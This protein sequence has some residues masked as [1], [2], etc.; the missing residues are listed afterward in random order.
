MPLIRLDSCAKFTLPRTPGKA[1]P[2]EDSAKV[3][4]VIPPSRC[5]TPSPATGSW[6]RT[7]SRTRSRTPCSEAGACTPW[8]P[9]ASG[10]GFR[11]ACPWCSLTSSRT[12]PRRGETDRVGDNVYRYTYIP[13]PHCIEISLDPSMTV[14]VKTYI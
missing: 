14:R 8:A 12:S 10:G 6:P 3:T 2:L 1:R 9:R 13:W 4:G 7:W 11:R 5:T